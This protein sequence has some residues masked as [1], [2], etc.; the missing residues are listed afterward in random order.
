MKCNAIVTALLAAG[1][2]ISAGVGAAQAAL[3]YR[4]SGVLDDGG[5]PNLGAATVFHCSNYGPT[6]TVVRVQ[7][8]NGAGELAAD[9]S[10]TLGSNITRTFSS[11]QTLAFE[12]YIWADPGVIKQ[13]SARI[14]STSLK[15]LCTAAVV[16]ADT[17]IP[18]G[19]VLHLSR[20]NP[21]AGQE[22]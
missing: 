16:P 22:E 8:F 9:M 6:S 7:I 11:H 17:A 13:G 19:A 18:Q 20:F 5:L 1:A 3:V 15:V 10:L 4:A 2:V 14:F 12:D 21:Q